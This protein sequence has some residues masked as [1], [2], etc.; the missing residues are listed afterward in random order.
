MSALAGYDSVALRGENIDNRMAVGG[1]DRMPGEAV[2]ADIVVHRIGGAAVENLRL[3]PKEKTLTPPGVSLL[4]G[5]TPEKVRQDARR[6]FP[7]AG[8]LLE[9]AATIGTATVAAIRAAGFDVIAD[10]TRHFPNHARLVHPKGIDGF[11][12]ANLAELCKVFTN[13]TRS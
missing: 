2:P 3:K 10:P 4:L 12:D 8:V 13:V 11:S 1:M 7:H 5:G 9:A 6:A